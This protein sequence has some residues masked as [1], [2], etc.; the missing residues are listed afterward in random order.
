MAHGP[1]RARWRADAA[2]L[3]ALRAV[4]CAE[5]GG[6]FAPWAM[7]FDHQDPDLKN[8]RVTSLVG[9]IGRKGLLAE[10]ALCDIVCANCHRERTFHRFRWYASKR[11]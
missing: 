3:D 1:Y 7:E 2:L 6:S 10:V 9:R 4:P 11:E 5:C 8:A